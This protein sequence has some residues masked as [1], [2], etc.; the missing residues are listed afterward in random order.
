MSD[1]IMM[2]L[3]AQASNLLWS[4]CHAVATA[5]AGQA[6]QHCL[7]LIELLQVGIST[8]CS[9]MQQVTMGSKRCVAVKP[10]ALQLHSS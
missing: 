2:G 9:G 3:S 7:G 5:F 8:S 4:G 10:G 1:I 6:G